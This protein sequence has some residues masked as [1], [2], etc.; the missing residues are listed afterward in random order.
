MG[1]MLKV[2]PP[3][4]HVNAAAGVFSAPQA[5][6]TRPKLAHLPAAPDA[7]EESVATGARAEVVEGKAEESTK[8]M[9]TSTGAIISPLAAPTRGGRARGPKAR[10]AGPTWC[11]GASSLLSCLPEAAVSPRGAC[12]SLKMGKAPSLTPTVYS[13]RS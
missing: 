8:R 1:G 13:R 12:P 11:E 3:S 9:K 10:S 5:N 6:P 7:A 4:R 2:S